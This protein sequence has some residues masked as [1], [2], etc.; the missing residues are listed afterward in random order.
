MKTPGQL[1]GMYSTYGIEI[2]VNNPW[3]LGYLSN[4]STSLKVHFVFL[5]LPTKQ[6]SL[7]FPHIFNFFLLTSCPQISDSYP[8]VNFSFHYSLSLLLCH[9]C[10]NTIFSCVA[11]SDFSLLQ[12]QYFHRCS[13]LNTQSNLGLDMSEHMWELSGLA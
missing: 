2:S 7:D 11:F 5:N 9:M 3:L 10:A 12:F 8:Q 1:I 4:Q 6:F 13:K